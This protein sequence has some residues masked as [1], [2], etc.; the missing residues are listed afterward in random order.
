LLQITSDNESEI[1]LNTAHTHIYAYFICKREYKFT[2]LGMP[3]GSK[4]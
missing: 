4:G 3:A 1:C 2:N